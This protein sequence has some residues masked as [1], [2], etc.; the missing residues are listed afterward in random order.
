M[1]RPKRELREE[2]RR[3]KQQGNQ[4]V[5]RAARRS[6]TDDPEQVPEPDADYGRFG[7][8]GRTGLDRDATRRRGEAGS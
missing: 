4:R 1:D 8:A 7:T 3:M 2:K 5:R 6:L